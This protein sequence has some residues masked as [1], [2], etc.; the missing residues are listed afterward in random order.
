MSVLGKY[1]PIIYGKVDET[2]LKR[3]RPAIAKGRHS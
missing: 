3:V 2:T 1:R